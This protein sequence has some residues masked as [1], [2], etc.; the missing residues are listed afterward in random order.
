MFNDFTARFT[1]ITLRITR[2]IIYRTWRV[3]ALV[4]VVMIRLKEI[5]E[6]GISSPEDTLQMLQTAW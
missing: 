2:A 1:G 3:H 6:S 4:D 5:L